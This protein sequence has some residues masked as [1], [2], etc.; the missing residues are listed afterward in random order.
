MSNST[1]NQSSSDLRGIDDIIEIGLQLEKL[2]IA[3]NRVTQ[4]LIATIF[5]SIVVCLVFVC[6]H[7]VSAIGLNEASFGTLK[8]LQ[9]TS[10]SFAVVMYLIRFYSL[11]NA[12]QQL[13]LTV[14]Q[15]RRTFES[16]VILEESKG[17]NEES[18]NKSQLLQKRLE[19][20]QY[21]AP[22]SPYAVFGINY[23]AFFATLATI[24]SYIV[25]LIKLRGVENSKA[26][27]NEQFMNDTNLI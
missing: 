18:K 2:I 20:Y 15:A 19:M 21:V 1:K 4:G 6:Y 11:M 14:K 23:K 10:G 17:L 5:S 13:S 8:T 12:G 16:K 9:V 24:V 7:V 22:I 25:I 27:T 26:T 3:T